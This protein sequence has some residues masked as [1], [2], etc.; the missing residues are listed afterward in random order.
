MR[1]FE[2]HP[3]SVK[4][5]AEAGLASLSRLEAS[6]IRVP[7]ILMGISPRWA[8]EEMFQALQ[9]SSVSLSSLVYLTLDAE[10]HDIEWAGSDGFRHPS[11][12]SERPH[13]S[14]VM[15]CPCELWG[16]T[17]QSWGLSGARHRYASGN[18]YRWRP[19]EQ[20]ML[21]GFS[22]LTDVY[23]NTPDGALHETL[24]IRIAELGI[25]LPTLRRMVCVS[26]RGEWDV[27]R[28][29]ETSRICVVSVK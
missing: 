23:L 27:R 11:W 6:I 25:G 13:L 8:L 10:F 15:A 14:E 1:R 20:R 26:G 12:D 18:V 5:M 22:R 7:D 16:D 19:H 29:I 17:L 24:A 9:G 28:V 21:R 4:Y 2:G 3:I